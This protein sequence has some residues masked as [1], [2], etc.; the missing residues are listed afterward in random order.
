MQKLSAFRARIIQIY[1]MI[2]TL[3]SAILELQKTYDFFH[4]L[5]PICILDHPGILD[6]SQLE[7]DKQINGQY[8]KMSITG[9]GFTGEEENVFI[10][11]NNEPIHVKLTYE[12][13]LNWAAEISL[14]KADITIWPSSK[15]GDVIENAIHQ[16]YGFSSSE[17]P[18]YYRSYFDMCTSGPNSGPECH[19]GYDK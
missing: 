13:H 9:W 4:Q 15:C 5:K 16:L 3:F 6:D 2:F 12:E 1:I 7:I 14:K 19:R 18:I 8:P 10:N 11:N 17:N